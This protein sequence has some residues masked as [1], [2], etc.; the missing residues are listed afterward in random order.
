MGWGYYHVLF[1][2]RALS[3]FN[4]ELVFK[5]TSDS[6]SYFNVF[7]TGIVFIGNSA[8]EWRVYDY[9]LALI[10]PIT[11]SYLEYFKVNF[12]MAP[13]VNFLNDMPIT[14]FYTFGNI[15]IGL[16]LEKM[17]FF[18]PPERLKKLTNRF[19]I[20]GFSVGVLCS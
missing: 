18:S 19:I 10:W 12:I 4:R 5:K 8:L 1:F 6:C 11:N 14:L 3:T 7:L 9:G 2:W 16:I 20:L 15:L 17:N 13:W